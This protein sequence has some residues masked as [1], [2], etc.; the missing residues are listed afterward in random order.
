VSKPFFL[1]IMNYEYEGNGHIEYQLLSTKIQ[2]LKSA[3]QYIQQQNCKLL[4]TR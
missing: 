1:P 4:L 3:K 2:D